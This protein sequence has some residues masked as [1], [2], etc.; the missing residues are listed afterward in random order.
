MKEDSEPFK[1]EA[2]HFL[3]SIAQRYADKIAQCGRKSAPNLAATQRWYP[4]KAT[5]TWLRASW[6]IMVKYP[7]GPVLQKLFVLILRGDYSSVDV[8][9][10]GVHQS[11]I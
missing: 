11:P 3:M 7:A 5:T 8:S 2:V 1:E 10:I 4:K 9:V 6:V